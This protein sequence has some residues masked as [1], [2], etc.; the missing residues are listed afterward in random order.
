MSV[1]RRKARAIAPVSETTLQW[2]EE[3]EEQL[4]TGRNRLVV[5][6]A[7]FALAFTLVGVRL[8]DLAVW[9]GSA[10]NQISLDAEQRPSANRADIV[11]RNGV[12]LATNL[13]TASL[14]A[15][16]RRILDAGDAA[17]KIVTALPELDRQEIEKK[18]TSGRAFI[19]LKR[20]LTPKQQN[21]VNALGVPGVGFR[22]DRKRVYP[23][24][25]LVAHVLGYTGIDNEGL[26]GIEK[27]YDDQLATVNR[28]SVSVTTGDPLRLSIDVRVQFALQ[29]EL[30]NAVD[31]FKALGA[32][33]IVLDAVTGEVIAMVSLPDFDPNQAR[34][35]SPNAMFNRAALGV[36][37]MGSTFKAFTT[38]MALDVGTVKI[39]G[40]YDATKP[41]RVARFT[42]RDD[43][44]KKRWLSVPEIFIY[45]SNI[46]AA[47]M[48]VDV[49]ADRQRE[50]LGRLGLLQRASLELPEVG[51][52]LSP[53]PWREVNTMT[54]GFGHGI[55]V[56]P[57]QLTGAMAALMNGGVRIDPTLMARPPMVT[58]VG[59]RVMKAR[60]SSIMKR[61]MRLNVESGT[62]TK[63]S[64]TGYLVGGKTGTAE[65]AGA[66]GYRRK[67]L[68]SSFIGAFP[69]NDPRYV[70][71]A[72]I[73]EPKGNK[74]T[75]GY[76]SGGW[77]AAPVFGRVVSRIGPLMGVTPVDEES[78]SVRNAMF[79]R[80]KA[81]G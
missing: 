23:H 50:F 29:Q 41:L 38:A 73:D 11:D 70:V 77:T 52:P 45:S 54:V 51:T 71:L 31:E 74:K 68:L 30:S 2:A 46:G 34:T 65:K 59:T 76:A 5:V 60:T 37:E 21:D 61:L 26:A 48:A 80:V 35:A 7:V 14:F 67:A 55:A 15:E 4:E 8:V 57:V 66:G 44:P 75:F 24:G 28:R 49:G 62:G 3:T 72:V 40:G 12:V 9:Q 79:I 1:F 20:H 78:K 6:G 25:N 63:A 33:G 69:M 53:S 47:K 22:D 32:A 27:Q 18:L 39:G 16:P 17:D 10:G 64:A 36:Y 13:T 19:W 81:G 58:P 43:H 42:I 56:S